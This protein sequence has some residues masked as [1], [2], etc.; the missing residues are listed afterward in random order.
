LG[1]SE[2]E[3]YLDESVSCHELESINFGEN[4]NTC[5]TCKAFAGDDR[6]A[7]GRCKLHPPSYTVSGFQFPIVLPSDWCL[8]WQSKEKKEPVKRR[9]RDGGCTLENYI[10]TCANGNIS[11]VSEKHKEFAKNLGIDHGPEWGKFVNYCKANDRRYA[12]YEAAFRNWLAEAAE[13][14]GRR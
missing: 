12:N 6:H 7:V 13:R 5:A 11:P 10:A 4:M 9:V 3:G 1:Q 14:K 8:D 2:V